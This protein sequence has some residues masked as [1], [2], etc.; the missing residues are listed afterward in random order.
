MSTQ[1]DFDEVFKRFSRVVVEL[2][3]QWQ[4]FRDLYS[5]PQNVVLFNDAAPLFFAHLKEYLLDLLYLSISRLFDPIKSC[6]DENLSLIKLVEY[7]EVKAIRGRLDTE[8]SRLKN[9]WSK[10]IKTW[11]HKMISHNDLATDDAATFEQP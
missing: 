4:M 11:R 8:C 2:H 7:P 3:T 1:S 5:K 6:G 9:I 10:G